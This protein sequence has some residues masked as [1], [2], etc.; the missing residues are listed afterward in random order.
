[1]L[2]TLCSN[3]F[4][5]FQLTPDKPCVF[6]TDVKGTDLPNFVKDLSQ[7]LVLSHDG[8]SVLVVTAV[9]KCLG[10]VLKKMMIGS[11]KPTRDTPQMGLTGASGGKAS[12]P[13]SSEPSYSRS[14]IHHAKISSALLHTLQN[15]FISPNTQA[16]SSF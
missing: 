12:K 4:E 15:S 11:R 16:E 2:S 5:E 7:G 8:D 6:L 10:I 3:F 9:A 1:M 13:A 14:E